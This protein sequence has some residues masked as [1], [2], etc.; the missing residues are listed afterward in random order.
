M[1]LSIA[2][3]KRSQLRPIETTYNG[4]RFRSRQE[5]RWAILLD[6]MGIQYRYETEG[7]LFGGLKYLPDF[8]LPRLDLWLE[9]KGKTPDEL[10]FEKA[11]RLAQG[12]K[13]VL[14]FWCEFEPLSF[15]EDN[16]AFFTDP[17]DVFR[18]YRGIAPLL[19][20][21]LT[22]DRDKLYSALGQARQARFEHGETPVAI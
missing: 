18:S 12:G 2:L 1:T 13:T 10:E 22:W 19:L 7:F 11:S 21:A 9:I 20:G 14:L 15:Y 3:D 4:Y 17:A 8:Y 16:L 5:A 6:A